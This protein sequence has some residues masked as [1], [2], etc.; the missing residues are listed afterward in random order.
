MSYPI[1]ELVGGIREAILDAAGRLVTAGVLPEG[2]LPAFTV[3]AINDRSLGDYSSNCAHVFAAEMKGDS[4]LMSEKLVK[5]ICLGGIPVSR[6]TAKNGYIN[7]AIDKSWYESTLRGILNGSAGYMDVLTLMGGINRLPSREEAD[8]S[9]FRISSMPERLEALLKS[10]SDY[11]LDCTQTDM[12]SADLTL[13]V[14]DEEHALIKHLAF[15]E[16]LLHGENAY[17]RL[18]SY[19]GRL[20]GLYDEFYAKC[21]VRNVGMELMTARALLITAVLKVM[22]RAVEMLGMTR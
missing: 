20:S 14:T 8:R 13:L 2:P 22:N 5:E 11:G 16:E 9:A 1:A 7:F 19:C 3:T 4:V 21:P 6:C 10:L 17:P 18:Q 12:N 15:F